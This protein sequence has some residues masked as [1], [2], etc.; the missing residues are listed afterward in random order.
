MSITK[1]LYQPRHYQGCS[2]KEVRKMVREVNHLLLNDH[3]TFDKA[4]RMKESVLSLVSVSHRDVI[5]NLFLI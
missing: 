1:K 5:A 3:I 4:K 2:C